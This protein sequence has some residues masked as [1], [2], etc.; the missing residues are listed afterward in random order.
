MRTGFEK[1]GPLAVVH[2]FL[3]VNH[4]NVIFQRYF[5]NENGVELGRGQV[6]NH[7]SHGQ[8]KGHQLVTGPTHE[9]AFD[10]IGRSTNNAEE[11]KVV[12]GVDAVQPDGGDILCVVCVCVWCLVGLDEDG[13][14]DQYQKRL[15]RTWRTSWGIASV[16]FLEGWGRGAWGLSTLAE[17]SSQ[18]GSV[19][20]GVQQEDAE[21][22]KHD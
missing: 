16:H 3:A 9:L 2:V 8:N 14:E 11:R 13:T 20:L 7:K 5:R 4:E 1:H 22:K 10:K 21:P 6:T 18:G 15:E 19:R 17:G 12:G